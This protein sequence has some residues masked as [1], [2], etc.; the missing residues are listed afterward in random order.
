M[1]ASAHASSLSL[2]S[3]VMP[4][5]PILPPRIRDLEDEAAY[6]AA[7]LAALRN[8]TLINMMD[9]C[10]VS[11]PAARPPESPVGLMLSAA[12]GGDRR[13]L[14]LAASVEELLAA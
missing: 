14:A 7:N 3:P 9:G 10:S 8:P 5:A 4:T 1:P 13:L 12:G 2:V 6:A 11:V